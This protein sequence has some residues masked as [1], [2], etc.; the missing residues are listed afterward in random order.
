MYDFVTLIAIQKL[1]SVEFAG[2]N[3]SLIFG[4]YSNLPWNNAIYP[5]ANV[6]NTNT[7]EFI[8]DSRIKNL[9][10]GS[11]ISINQTFGVVENR[12]ITA[13]TDPVASGSRWRRTITFSGE[14]IDLIIP[15]GLPTADR[16]KLYCSAQKTGATDNLVYHTGRTD[17][18]VGDPLLANQFRYR[19][20]EGLWGTVGEFVD[21]AVVKNLRLY[22]DYIS[23]NYGN[24][25]LSHKINFKIPLQNTYSTSQNPLPQYIKKM[26][27]DFRHPQI[28]VPSE[29]T[30]DESFYGDGFYSVDTVGPDGQSYDANTIF[31]G[32]SSMAWDGKYSN[33]LY[34]LRFW[35]PSTTGGAWL[36]GSRMI[37]RHFG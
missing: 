4:G 12:E 23:A 16:Q 27:I 35:S 26:G 24:T 37:K 20:M 1:F 18:N 21:G 22:W 19:W 14:P 6:T 11:I 36:Y 3:T 33:G 29:L 17:Y 32:C 9:V 13:I 8:G 2:I 31:V 25:E 10:V 7:G 28:T 15:D 34:C 5:H 30:D